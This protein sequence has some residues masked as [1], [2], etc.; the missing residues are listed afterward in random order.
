MKVVHLQFE[1]VGQALSYLHSAPQPYTV[2]GCV[3]MT[4]PARIRPLLWRLCFNV[5]R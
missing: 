1:A 5:S 3:P 2:K 4:A